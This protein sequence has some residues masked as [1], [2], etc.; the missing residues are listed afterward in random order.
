MFFIL[1]SYAPFHQM[2]LERRAALSKGSYEDAE[3]TCMLIKGLLRIDCTPE[4]FIGKEEE[5]S[6]KAIEHYVELSHNLEPYDEFTRG[7]LLAF[8][9]Q[10]HH[11]FVSVHFEMGGYLNYPDSLLAFIRYAAGEYSLEQLKSTFIEI[12]LFTQSLRFI[13]SKYFR[14][15]MIKLSTLY[16]K[17]WC[18]R[19]KRMEKRLQASIHQ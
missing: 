7:T 6:N 16:H 9:N 4:T 3:H 2:M 17:I 19:Q 1:D 13:D 10:I 18:K 12:S 11:N 15:D 5:H 8:Y 14:Q